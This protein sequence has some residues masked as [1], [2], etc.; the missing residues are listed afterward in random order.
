MFFK[1]I[2]FKAILLYTLILTVTLLIF[3]FILYG[4]FCKTLYDDFDDL[5]SSRAEGVADS[6]NAYW[7]AH[8]TAYSPDVSRVLAENAGSEGFDSIASSWVEEKRKD[9]DLM[10]IFVQILDTGGNRIVAS[11]SMPKLSQLDEEDF[12]DI[13]SGED[14]FDTLNGESSGGKKTKFRAYSKPVLIG[15]KAWYVVQVAGPIDLMSIA[16]NNLIFI[17]FILL[18]LTVLLA[19]FPGV[20]LVRIAL[21][22]VDTMIDTLRQITAENLKLKIHIPDTKDEIKRLAETFNDM[23]GRLDRSFSSQRKFIQAISRELRIPVENLKEEL[24]SALTKKC[25]EEEYRALLL[26]AAKEADGLSRTIDDLSIMSRLGEERPVLEVRKVNLTGLVESVF[27][28]MKHEAA[29]KEINTSISCAENVKIDGD[30]EQLKQLLNNLF[31]NAVRYTRRKGDISVVVRSRKKDS[32]EIIISDT[33]V[34]IPEDELPYIFDRFY[35][36]AKPRGVKG[37]F[38][39]GLS[40]ARAI[41]EAHK[42]AITVESREGKGSA[43]TVTLPLNYPG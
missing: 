18:P 22:P 12:A 31:E 17:L 24:E 33:G 8:I 35:Q 37:G 2:R 3:S 39:L 5:L 27:K 41:V 10:N 42:G 11:K 19:A 6:I 38:G 25:P 13:L 40:T 26:K 16:L 1:S 29:E 21:K 14:S 30:R 9:P 28:D 15:G 20:L 36:V 7:H 32:A 43:F 34:G 23:I 4:G